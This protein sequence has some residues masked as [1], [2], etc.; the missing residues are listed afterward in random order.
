MKPRIIEHQ[1]TTY[2]VVSH[3]GQEK[4]FL[5]KEDAVSE[6]A[7]AMISGKEREFR[8]LGWPYFQLLH[9]RLVRYLKWRL[10]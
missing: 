6:L 3:K 7:W 4:H 1:S 2:T 10:K 9:D 8:Y 5:T